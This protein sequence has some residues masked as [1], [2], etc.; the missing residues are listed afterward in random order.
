MATSGSIRDRKTSGYKAALKLLSSTEVTVGIHES[1]GSQQH[2][3]AD[4]TVRELAEIH[5]FG[6]GVP[7]RSFIR[8]WHDANADEAR[9]VL[10]D[11]LRVAVKRREPLQVGLERFALWAQADVQKFISAGNVK[12]ELA[13]STKDRKGSSIPLID[14]GVLRS[15]ILGKVGE[16]RQ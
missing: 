12:P 16:V 1:E 11:Q 13:D 4:L 5:E 15:A 9:K 10:R 2:D 7:E 14:T 8:A 6:Q 3:G